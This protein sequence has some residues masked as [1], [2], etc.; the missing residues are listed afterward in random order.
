MVK[1][2]FDNWLLHLLDLT[3]ISRVYF[4]FWGSMSF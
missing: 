2:Y 3:C 1:I 4:R